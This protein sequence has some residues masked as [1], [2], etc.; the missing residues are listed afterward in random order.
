MTAQ[1][2]LCAVEPAAPVS[3]HQIAPNS[4]ERC[5]LVAAMAIQGSPDEDWAA[6]EDVFA[7]VVLGGLDI[8][9]D[10]DVAGGAL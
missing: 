3:S 1:S 6:R 8:Q 2:A 7:A 4:S 10:H 9:P 5:S